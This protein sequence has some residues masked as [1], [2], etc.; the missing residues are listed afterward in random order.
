ML[1]PEISRRER[2]RTDLMRRS[3]ALDLG[4]ISLQRRS[5]RS[6]HLQVA[7]A[8][9]NGILTGR[10]RP[11]ARLPST[12]LLAA[13]LNV[14]RNTTSAA[15]EQLHSEGFLVSVV[16]SGTRV[17]TAIP[18]DFIGNVRG[19]DAAEN[20]MDSGPHPLSQ[21]AAPIA[22]FLDT[23]S[24]SRPRPFMSGM[25]AID[26][27][28]FGQWTA[29][30]SRHWR[31]ATVSD[32]CSPNPSS[33]VELRRAIA[34]HVGS[35][36]GCSGDESRILVLSGAQQGL[37]L[38]A[39]ILSDPGDICWIEEPGYLG[40]RYALS[41]AGLRLMPAPVDQ[42]G[43]NIEL[44]IAT[45][46]PPRLIYVTPSHQYPLGGTLPIERRV[47]LL[48]YAKRV[49]AWIIEDDYDSEDA[50]VRDPVPCLLGLDPSDR[51]I[52]IGSFNKT[53]FPG[54]RLGFV[55]APPE[56]LPA[57]KAARM[58]VDGH[59]PAVIQGVMAE[60]IESGAF[61][62]H[63][64]QMRNEY[65]KRRNILIDAL[66]EQLP[67]LDLGVHDRGLHFVAYLPDDFNDRKCVA[68]VE[69]EGLALTPL[70]RFY[71]NP[72]T[73]QGLVLGFACVVPHE[74]EGAVK[75]LARALKPVLS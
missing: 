73:R 29:L 36:R 5:G 47:A 55:L 32:L 56:V 26:Q 40:A 54:L 31:A 64:R 63:I 23:R 27:F 22:N 6:L 18:K 53:M 50:Y 37:D 59:P 28:P 41:M 2:I 33:G 67:E 35:S 1:A 30:V 12:R 19:D 58:Y 46:P 9:R 69:K 39:R 15:F 10:L 49:G 24:N 65:S 44:A 72:A 75:S 3:P 11:G 14:S 66:R 52:Y 25:P 4:T 7:D 48:Q 21:K 51:V 17:T 8:I 62:S 60:F 68:L 20:A 13:E 38:T 61:V 57:F 70:S 43:I 71:I 42:A 16:G 34:A 45:L 74:I